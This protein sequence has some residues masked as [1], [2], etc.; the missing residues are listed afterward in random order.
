MDISILATIG[1]TSAAVLGIIL[2]LFVGPKGGT[3]KSAAAEPR[4][5]GDTPA[6][7]EEREELAEGGEVPEE[8]RE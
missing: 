1:F 7:A 4:E 5:K 2:L 6:P 3:A 8:E